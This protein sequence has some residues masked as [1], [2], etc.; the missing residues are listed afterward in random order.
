MFRLKRSNMA[1]HHTASTAKNLKRKEEK[2]DFFYLFTVL[3]L[4][5]RSLDWKQ[6]NP[7][8]THLSTECSGVFFFFLKG[9]VC[10]INHIGCLVYSYQGGVSATASLL[11]YRKK[12]GRK[13]LKHFVSWV[14]SCFWLTYIA[15]L[16]PHQ[17]DP[18]NVTT[19]LPPLKTN[20]H[21][22][23]FEDI[24]KYR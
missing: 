17:P 11:F 3:F 12:K 19:L 4:R 7:S 24:N 1:K 13:H 10:T 22:S 21:T 18:F 2:S 5:Q 9:N 15:S 23:I 8:R 6:T 20:K 14:F 16:Q